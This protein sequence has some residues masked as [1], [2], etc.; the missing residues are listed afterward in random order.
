[1]KEK[2]LA[3]KNKAIEWIRG[4]SK[5]TVIVAGAVFIIALAV[6]LNLILLGDGTVPGSDLDASIDLSGVGN[7]DGDTTVNPINE[8]F[9]SMSLSRQTSRE[10][11]IAVLNAIAES[12]TAVSEMKEQAMDNIASIAAAME[13]E[14]N[15]ETLVKAKGFSKCL[16]II[17]NGKATVIV[18]SDGLL[19]SQIAQIS[20]IVHD[21]S[22]ILP[23]D[24]KIIEKSN[25]S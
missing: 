8:Y 7:K 16:A 2:L 1:M 20:E 18:E 24:L 6:V 22:G 4:L 12:E 19:P 5:K 15:I 13:K 23:A 3:L 25:A 11:A 9:A 14:A 10:E 21:Q 17:E